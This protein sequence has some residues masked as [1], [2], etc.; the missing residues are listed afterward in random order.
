[1]AEELS[2]EEPQALILDDVLVNT[3]VMLQQRVLDLLQA[4][5][6]K[7]QILVVTCHPG[8]YHGIGQL[9]QIQS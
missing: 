7:F 3:D 2:T 8:R 6:R 5:A 1:M 9:V 4:A